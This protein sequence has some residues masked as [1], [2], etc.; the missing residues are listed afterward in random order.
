MKKRPTI[1]K[2]AIWAAADQIEANGAY[3]S[4]AAVRKVLGGGSY[5]TITAAMEERK[6]LPRTDLAMFTSPIPEA[7]SKRFEAL[8]EEVWAAAVIHAHERWRQFVD[9]LDV[10]LKAAETKIASQDDEIKRLKEK[11]HK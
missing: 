11:K 4:L 7:L 1:T 8:G 9:E 10:A 6:Q 2:E 5:T 3:A